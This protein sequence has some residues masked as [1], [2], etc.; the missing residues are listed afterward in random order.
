MKLNHVQIIGKF[1]DFYFSNIYIYSASSLDS[2]I[3]FI[4]N[5]KLLDY[6]WFSHEDL[7]FSAG[8]SHLAMSDDTNCYLNPGL[9]G[10]FYIFPLCSGP[11]PRR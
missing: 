2:H 4:Q 9:S 7:H 6:K 11:S 5:P 10:Q 1:L 8:N 3:G